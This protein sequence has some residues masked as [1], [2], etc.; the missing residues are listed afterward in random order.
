MSITFSGQVGSNQATRK[1]SH[2]VRR[3][4]AALCPTRSPADT[5]RPAQK[6]DLSSSLQESRAGRA[7][8]VAARSLAEVAVHASF[9]SPEKGQEME[10]AI[11]SCVWLDL[12][13]WLWSADILKYFLRTPSPELPLG[14]NIFSKMKTVSADMGSAAAADSACHVRMVSSTCST[15]SAWQASFFSDRRLHSF[16]ASKLATSRILESDC[17]RSSPCLSL[18]RFTMACSL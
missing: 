2:S 4:S 10:E 3:S 9:S 17:S 12:R 14:I 1:A 11:F 5:G 6:G 16:S 13:L 7:P 15:E 18:S 8:I